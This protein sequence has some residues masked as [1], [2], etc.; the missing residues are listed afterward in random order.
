MST[1]VNRLR[2]GL[3]WVIFPYPVD[4][5]RR[6]GN[7]PPRPGTSQQRRRLGPQMPGSARGMR[8]DTRLVGGGCA[9]HG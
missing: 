5:E 7:G 8:Q 9:P 6:T 1:Q 3:P 4:S 2:Q